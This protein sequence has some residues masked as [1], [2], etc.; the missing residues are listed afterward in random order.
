MKTKWQ[1]DR[2]MSHDTSENPQA[3]PIASAPAAAGVTFGPCLLWTKEACSDPEWRFG[4]WDG[5]VWYTADGFIVEP[6]YW[7][8]LPELPRRKLRAS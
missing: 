7:S 5:A 4:G 6:R 8:P 1:E 2:L 3:R